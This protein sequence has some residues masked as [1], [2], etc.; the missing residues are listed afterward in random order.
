MRINS[1]SPMQR[2]DFITTKNNGFYS[3]TAKK[4][5]G[6]GYDFANGLETGMTNTG[7]IRKYPE[8]NKSPMRQNP[9]ELP[10]LT[11]MA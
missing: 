10:S 1:F 4:E 8:M 5:K 11:G 6:F 9:T 2:T 7:S 3:T